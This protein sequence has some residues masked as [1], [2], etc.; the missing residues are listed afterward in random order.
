M[1]KI[2]LSQITCESHVSH[3]QQ[4]TSTSVRAM[5]DDQVLTFSKPT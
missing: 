1:N 2:C 5:H 4:W 3:A